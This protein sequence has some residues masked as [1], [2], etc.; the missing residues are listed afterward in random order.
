[1]L[2]PGL[3]RGPVT[4]AA[5]LATMA[6][7]LGLTA[8]VAGFRAAAQTFGS[9]SGSVVDSTNRTIS[10]VTLVLIG[11]PNQ[12]KHELQSDASGHFEFIGLPPGAY[13]LEASTPGFA[14]FRADLVVGARPLQQVV[15]LKVGSLMET[16][17]V[18]GVGDARPRR[19]F[20]EPMPPVSSG[21]VSKATGGTIE[22][23]TKLRDVRPNYPALLYETKVEGHVVL[24]ARIGTDGA[25]GELRVVTPAH[26]DLD[27]AA[28]EAVRQWRF[29][30]TRLNCVP[31]EVSM[32]VHVNFVPR[33]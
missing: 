17:T 31:I 18:S 24:D 14:T 32:T 16:V 13:R 27:A 2:N 20:V 23:P 30:Q 4:R 33:P 7:A 29:S 9:V 26:P 19:D 10:D 22:Q 5:R 8:S 3:N 25:V 15:A 6:V 11:A 12:A 1:M 28:L 21:C